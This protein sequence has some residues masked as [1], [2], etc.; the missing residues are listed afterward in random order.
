V[1]GSA[2]LSIWTSMTAML[3][4]S[5]D[6]LEVS[7]ALGDIWQTGGGSFGYPPDLVQALPKELLP[8]A[9]AKVRAIA[10]PLA[11]TYG[12]VPTAT[13]TVV[14]ATLRSDLLGAIVW[15]HSHVL[16][17]Q[18]KKL[19]ARYHELSIDT[20]TAVLQIA[21]N[22]DPKVAAA[23]RA[24]VDK[25]VDPVVRSVLLGVLE[26]LGD[27]DRYRTTLASIA[28]D[29]A[30]TTE[31]YASIW[32]TFADADTLPMLEAY[33]REHY[34]EIEKRLP[35]SDT[36]IFPVGVVPAFS[37]TSACDPARRDEIATYVTSHFASLPA[38]AR[39][40]KQAI[41]M[42]D[43]CIARKKLLEPALRAWLTGKP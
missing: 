32:Y 43:H 21:A 37:I 27:P 18:A 24:D 23:L 10:E 6:V 17:A 7:A 22:A 36:A 15:S 13:D 2:P 16:D 31:E 41:E 29:P 19:V 9:R 30:L 33:E 11:R 42:M 8:A 20:M 4:R 34:D 1:Q 3:G 39:P 38:A 5:R 12:L 26:R 28:T 35:V 25:E 40:V 14:S